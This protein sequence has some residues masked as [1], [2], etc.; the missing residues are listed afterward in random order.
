[1]ISFIGINPFRDEVFLIETDNE[2]EKFLLPPDYLHVKFVKYPNPYAKKPK[3]IPAASKR[4]KTVEF[5][6]ETTFFE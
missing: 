2:E 4:F 1:M 6:S 5:A 3:K